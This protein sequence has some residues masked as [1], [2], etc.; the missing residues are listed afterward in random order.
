MTGH[1]DAFYVGERRRG[2]VVGDSRMLA[3]GKWRTRNKKTRLR[4]FSEL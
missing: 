4:R 3:C 2:G 1:G